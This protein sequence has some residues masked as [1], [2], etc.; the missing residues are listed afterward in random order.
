MAPPVPERR[1]TSRGWLRGAYVYGVALA[2]MAAALI[3]R[4]ALAGLVDE[5][6]LYLLTYHLCWWPQA[7][8]GLVPDCWPPPSPSVRRSS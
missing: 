2:A 8:E 7:S 6:G 1:T 3:V 5:H 4:A